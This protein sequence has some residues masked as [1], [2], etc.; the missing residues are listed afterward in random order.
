MSELGSVGI[1]ERK[2]FTFADAADPMSLDCGASLGPITLA[3]ETYG[4][5]N[6]DSSNAILLTHAL[7][8]DA[9]VAGRHAEEDKKPGWWDTMVGPGKAFDTNRFFIICSNVLGG[10]QGSTGPS[11]IDPTTGKPFGLTF[12]IITIA[13]MVRAQ[14]ELIRHLGI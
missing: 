14:R 6:A 3:Y 2:Q 5:L 4:A 7:S 11:S 8:G 1:V 9:H 10:C 12:P 13:D